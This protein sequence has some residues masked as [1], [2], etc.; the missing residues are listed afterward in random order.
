[1][2]CRFAVYAML[3]STTLTCAAFITAGCGDA[4]DGQHNTAF[5]FPYPATEAYPIGD[6]DGDGVEDVLLYLNATDFFDTF[7]GLSGADGQQLGTAVRNEV[8]ETHLNGD[9]LGRPRSVGDIDGDGRAELLFETSRGADPDV[10]ATVFNVDS[11]GD[12]LEFSVLAVLPGDY[13]TTSLD[14]FNDLDGDGIDDFLRG[15]FAIYRNPIREESN[16]WGAGN[17]FRFDSAQ[18]NEEIPLRTFDTHT[19]QAINESYSARWLAIATLGDADG[20][21]NPDVGVLEHDFESQEVTLSRY[22]GGPATAMGEL[23]DEH[24][25]LQPAQASAG[26]RHLLARGDAP[27]APDRFF[28]GQADERFSVNARSDDETLSLRLFDIDDGEVALIRDFGV[29]SKHFYSD[30]DFDSDGVNDLIVHRPD[31]E[32]GFGTIEVYFGPGFE[33]TRRYESA[34]L[35]TVIGQ[36]GGAPTRLVFNQINRARTQAG[37]RMVSF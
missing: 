36:R 16:Y 26:P 31:G 37:V 19:F 25:A 11:A 12:T 7:L 32:D 29:I 14:A 15:T 6:L 1:M 18:L 34:R 24:L 4:E 20:D 28:I 5:L 33:S 27:G 8:L 30:V 10:Q 3:A 17:F 9:L 23:I 2:K 13:R 35:L 21:G 22:R